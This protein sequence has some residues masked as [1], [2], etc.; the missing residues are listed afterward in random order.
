MA[1]QGMQKGSNYRD[2]PLSPVTEGVILDTTLSHY[3][4]PEGSISWA[5]NLHNDTLGVMTAR[6]PLGPRII[7]RDTSIGINPILWAGALNSLSDNSLLYWQGSGA[8]LKKVSLNTGS[9]DYYPSSPVVPTTITTT[10]TL[11]TTPSNIDF[12][13][14]YALF[15]DSSGKLNYYTSGA[16]ATQIAGAA[17]GS[18]KVISAGFSGR[19]WGVDNNSSLGRVYYSDVIPS[20]GVTSTTSTG[21]YITVNSSEQDI[22]VALYKTQNCLFVFTTS[23]VYRVYSTQSVDNSPCANVGTISQRAVVGG[24]DGIYFANPQGIFKLDENG[25]AT[26]VSQRLRSLLQNINPTNFSY[27]PNSIPNLYTAIT[28]WAD[29]DNVYFSYAYDSNTNMPVTMGEDLGKSYI[30]KFHIPSQNWSVYSLKGIRI[31]AAATAPFVPRPTTGQTF[32][33]RTTKQNFMTYLMIIND[34]DST[35]SQVIVP[36]LLQNLLTPYTGNTAMEDTGSSSSPIYIKYATTWQTF[37]SEAHLKKVNGI[38]IASTYAGGL[39]IGYVVD[40]EDMT[41]IKTIGELSSDYVTLFR[42]FQSAEFN[43]IKFIIT[44]T[45][46]GPLTIGQ[47][48]VLG[49]DDLGYSRN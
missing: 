47:I 24:K 27:N 9:T 30:L 11:N 49:L 14:G 12:L 21:N 33:G 43:R 10:T 8:A 1:E 19:I 40:G 46:L 42:D 26:D 17:F 7:N 34:N 44:G 28:S 31:V 20:S 41:Q 2:I 36:F 16:A 23:S 22:T 45:A 37:G 5:E 32:I 18:A 13:Q 25:N 3:I 29:E 6:Y 35:N 4:A 48:T 38:S 15:L 39:Q